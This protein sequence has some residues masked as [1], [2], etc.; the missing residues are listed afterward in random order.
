MVNHSLCFAVSARARLHFTN[1]AR[2]FANSERIEQPKEARRRRERGGERRGHPLGPELPPSMF[3]HGHVVVPLATRALL[4][5]DGRCARPICI[6]TGN[7]VERRRPLNYDH[8]LPTYVGL[9]ATGSFHLV[10]E[11]E[12]EMR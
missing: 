7:A 8:F 11:I 10:N 4:K 6:W 9:D 5:I 12:W 2:R 3:N 1:P